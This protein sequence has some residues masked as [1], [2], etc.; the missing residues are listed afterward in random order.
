MDQNKPG[1]K[2]EDHKI[3]SE[4]SRPRWVGC[5]EDEPDIRSCLF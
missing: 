1:P 2:Y 3:Q 4:L 5:E